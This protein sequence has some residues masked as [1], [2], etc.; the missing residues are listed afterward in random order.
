MKRFLLAALLGAVSTIL[1]PLSAGEAKLGDPAPALQIAEWVKGKP[2]NLADLKGKNIAVIEFWATWCPPCRVS[3][4]HLTELQKKFKDVVIVGISDEDVATVKKFVAKMG[5]QMDY[6]VAVDQEEKTGQ[7]YMGGFGVDGIPHAFVVDKEGRI[8]W[9]GHPMGDLER[10]LEE[11][12]AGKFDLAKARKRT[13]AQEKLEAFQEAVI[14]NDQARIETLGRE[15]EAL[16][17]EVGPL[18]RDRKFDA[19][20]I[21][22]LIRFQMTVAEYQ[23]ALATEAPAETL[24]ALEKRLEELAPKDFDLAGMKRRLGQARLFGQYFRAVTGRGDTNQLE[25][26]GGQLKE[27]SGVH[28]ED[29]NEWAWVLLT[30]P[31]VRQRDLA[32]ATQLAKAALDASGGTNASILDTYARALFDT[33]K[34][35]EAIEYQKKAIAVAEDEPTRQ[36]LRETLRQYE[37]KARK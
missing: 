1:S 13:E 23:Q 30:D 12:Q 27:L 6:V 4:P 20:E 33:G 26:L 2:V 7:A 18:L 9:H 24:A 22:N 32:L 17:A 31:R 37:A 35:S 15:L 14:Q 19:A 28:P 34:V 25:K 21:R 11:L 3:I 16:D 5:D 8:V 10:V 36:A 29:L